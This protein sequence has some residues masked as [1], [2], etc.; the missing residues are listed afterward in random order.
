[1]AESCSSNWAGKFSC[2]ACDFCGCAP[3]AT[4]AFLGGGFWASTSVGRE[5]NSRRRKQN[6][7]E[8][9]LQRNWSRGM[10]V[11]QCIRQ[12]RKNE[13]QFSR[14]HFRPRAPIVFNVITFRGIATAKSYGFLQARE[15]IQ[16]PR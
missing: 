14:F 7:R 12:W 5:A 10:V 15:C 3:N 4:G 9:T 2:S 11:G 13:T 8:I 6:V 16:E 1:M